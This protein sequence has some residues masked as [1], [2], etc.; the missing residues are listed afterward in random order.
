MP[1][2][3]VYIVECSDRSLYTGITNDIARRVREH[4]SKKGGRYTRAHGTAR[5]VWREVHPTRSSATK[6]EAQIKDLTR[7]EKQ[8][9]I[10][11]VGRTPLI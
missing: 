2:W 11:E 9:L 5:L 8:A 4:N 7:P 6:R 1:D 3:F 10:F